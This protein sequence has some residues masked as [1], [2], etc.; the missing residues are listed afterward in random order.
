M[1][2]YLI[3]PMIL[4]L[5]LVVSACLADEPDGSKNNAS[6]ITDVF[7]FNYGFRQKVDLNGMWE[8]RK[9]SEGD[10]IEEGWQEGKGSFDRK[11]KIPGVPQSQGLGVS[12]GSMKYFLNEPF[13]VRRTFAMPKVGKNKHVW[14]R[15]GGVLPAAQVYLNGRYIGYTKSSRTQQRVD[16]T[17]FVKPDEPNLIAIKVCDWPKVKLEGIWEMLE[18]RITWT[19]V[20]RPVCL[21]ITD[22][23]SL[24]DAYIQP[25]L[26]SNSAHVGVELSRPAKES[27]TVALSALDGG[28]TIGSASVTIPAGEKTTRVDVPLHDYTEWSPE[29]PKLYNMVIAVKDNN[30][31]IDKVGIRFGMREITTIGEKFYLNGKPVFMRAYGDDQLYTETIAPPADKSWYVKRLKM[32]R[33]YGFNSAK[34]CEEIFNQDYLEAADEAGIMIIQEMPFGLSGYVRVHQH[35]LEEPWRKFYGKELD[36]LVKESRNNPSVIAYSMCS[37]V[38]LDSGTQEAFD[39]FS[40]YCTGRA[41]ELA[42]SCI[43]ID[44]T[45][46]YGNTQTPHGD[47]ITDFYTS[48]IPTWCKRALDET[49][50]DSDGKHPSMLHEYSWWSCYPDPQNKSKYDKTPLIPWW[51]DEAEKTAKANGQLDLIPSYV[52]NSAY[53]QEI[54]RKDGFEYARRSPNVEGYIYWLITDYGQ[55]SEGLLDDFWKPKNVS[56][57]EFRKCNGETVIVLAK[58]GNRCLGLGKEQV[59]PLAVSHYGEND[60]KDSI[61]KWSAV[62][63]TLSTKGEIAIPSMRSGKLTQVGAVELK[64]PISDKGYKFELK[65]SLYKNGKLVNANNWLFWALPEARKSLVKAASGKAKDGDVFFRNGQYPIPVGTSLV[66]ADSID[67]E[68]ADYV[69]AGG[70]CLLF[71]KSSAIEEPFGGYAMFRT[72]PWNGGLG[73]CGTV[74]SDNPALA[75]FPHEDVCDFQFAWL[76]KTFQPMNFEELRKYNITPIIRGIDCY[77]TNKNLAYMMEFKVGQGKVLVTSLGVLPKLAERLEARS[78]LETLVDYSKSPAFAPTAHLPKEEFV[79]FFSTASE[80]R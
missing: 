70:K 65:A 9:E 22:D 6:F 77:R 12:N 38:P 29:H 59:I 32:A 2:R 35:E 73:N 16:V 60:L 14:L 76:I 33:A 64:L 72:L 68:L 63:G 40:R 58:E 52:K 17:A 67:S 45:G 25:K 27:V 34:S 30:G 48:M 10:A 50:L 26:S 56:A 37:E 15:L 54:C 19:G 23:V 61:L 78:M 4:A 75:D 39:F 13:W 53:I 20:Y 51:L 11:I 5:C 62:G 66:V 46:Y 36:G 18:S 7:S 28:R 24:V 44:N 3:A 41:K 47:R 57:R 43:V 31:E 79:K 71:S 42:P 21:E 80:K 55:Y 69:N 49:P 8:F 1:F 74:I